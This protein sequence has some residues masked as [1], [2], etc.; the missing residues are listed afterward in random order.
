MEIKSGKIRKVLLLFPPVVNARFTNNICELPLGIAS[1]AAW[2]KDQVDVQCLD[3]SEQG[4]HHQEPF[5]KGLIRFG[6][7]DEE[8]IKRIEQ[9]KPDLVGFSC[10]FSSQFPIIRRLAEQVKKLDPSIILVAG[11]THPSFLPEA[12]LGTSKLDYIVLGEGET[13]FSRLIEAL[14]KDG[15][16]M[17]LPGIAWRQ[18][19]AIRINSNVSYLNDLSQLPFPARELFPV[20]NYFRINVPMQSLSRSRRNLAIATSRGCPYRCGFCSSTIHWGLCYRTRPVERVIEELKHLKDR[21]RI[22]EVKFEDDNLTADRTRAREL[23]KRM[24]DERLNLKWNTPNGIAVWSL[25]EEMLE[26]MKQSGC[27]E[28]TVAVESGDPWVL[29]NLIKKPVNLQKTREMVKV[30]KK[31]GIETSGY[32]IIGFPGETREQIM[33]TINYARSLE[34]D[35]CYI[36]IFTPLPGTPLAKMAMESGRLS[37]DHNFE[38]AN[39]YFLPRLPLS[40]VPPEELLKIHRRAFWSINLALLYKHPI[41]FFKK[42]WNS[43]KTH[44]EYIIKF[45]RAI[46]Q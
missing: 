15:Q 11:G 9:I 7:S 33:N 42:Y 27:Y 10:L 46:F 8:I 22:E 41:R 3:A 14:N 44:P 19:D 35:R 23:F 6:L 43:L 21:Y 12:C 20:E 39:N 40:E 16:A 26:M 5:G 32:F 1:L 29:K 2:V 34:L 13:S 38:D 45:F 37:R 25:D 4:Y 31:L 18:D 24:I 17:G 30:I 36:F 28:I